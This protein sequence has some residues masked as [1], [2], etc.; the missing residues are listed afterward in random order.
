MASYVLVVDLGE[1]AG[2]EQYAALNELMD[3]LGFT[4]RGPET[5]LPAQF[6][7]I[8]ALPLRGIKR[9]VEDR[10]RAELLPGVTVDAYEIKRLLQFS[11]VPAL[12]C[13]RFH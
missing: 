10:I 13:R 7:L 3:E 5:L 6:S 11:I 1:P 9:M 8:S 4:L 12:R 2:V